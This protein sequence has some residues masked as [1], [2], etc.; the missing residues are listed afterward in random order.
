MLQGP[1]PAQP[2]PTVFEIPEYP[3]AFLMASR[4]N[5]GT[6]MQLMRGRSIRDTMQPLPSWEIR[7]IRVDVQDAFR[8]INAFSGITGEEGTVYLERLP[9]DWLGEAQ[10]AVR[11]PGEE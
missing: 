5:G 8:G 4:L 1:R 9:F 7:V 3:E 2:A 6:S 11:P 10:V